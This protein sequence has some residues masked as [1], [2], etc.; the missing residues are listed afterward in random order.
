MDNVKKIIQLFGRLS[1]SEKKEIVNF[2]NNEFRI[3]DSRR[4]KG[5]F[6]GPVPSP[7]NKNCAKCGKPL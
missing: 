4:P 3:E 1:E 7:E 5:I 6:L 2:F